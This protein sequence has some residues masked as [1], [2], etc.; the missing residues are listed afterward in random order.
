LKRRVR[1][2]TGLT[3]SVGVAPSKLVAKIAC[4]LGKPDGCL[5]V[6]P[7]AVRWLLDPLPVRRLWGIGPVLGAKLERSGIRSIGD[8]ASAPPA[9]LR[10]IMGDRAEHVRL[11]ARGEDERPVETNREPK[12][13]GEESTFEV[14]VDDRETILAALGAH[15]EA[16]ARRARHA[17]Y[18]GFT[19]TIKIKLARRRRVRESRLGGEPPEPVYPLS[20][21]A[22]TLHAPTND[23]AVIRRAAHSLWDAAGVR[24]PVRL[25][26]VSLSALRA[27][28]AQQLDLFERP[29]NTARLAPV[30][31]EIRDRFGDRAISH[32]ISA[33]D[34]VTPSLH[35]RPGPRKS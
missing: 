2:A 29:A 30:L 11:L 1:E 14:D 16:V 25:L 21:R 15:A 4:S 7:E 35:K 19:V 34:K 22:T 20:T 5:L 24:E 28:A 26:G 33:P 3:V 10:E 8:L 31:D 6:P 27:P 12:S 18:S 17:G 9:T 13:I 32:A 23:G